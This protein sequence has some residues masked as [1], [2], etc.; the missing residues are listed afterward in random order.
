MGSMK[1]SKIFLFFSLIMTTSTYTAD[2]EL[3]VQFAGMQVDNTGVVTLCDNFSGMQVE[4]HKMSLDQ[5]RSEVEGA[6]SAPWDLVLSSFLEQMDTQSEQEGGVTAIRFRDKVVLPVL[7]TLEMGLVTRQLQFDFN[8][9]NRLRT[10]TCAFLEWGF[11]E[12]CNGS[13]PQSSDTNRYD[14]AR[15]TKI[16][17]VIDQQFK[18]RETELHYS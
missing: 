16:Q 2:A 6:V 12:L 13:L 9:L 15:V 17:E 10:N 4:E 11:K 8:M 1:I 3:A 14:V 5:V 18:Q 7:E